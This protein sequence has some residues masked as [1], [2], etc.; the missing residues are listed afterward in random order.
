MDKD[1]NQ[2]NNYNLYGT[3]EENNNFE[4]QKIHKNKRNVKKIFA[5]IAIALIIALTGGAIGGTITYKV[6]VKNLGE[7]NITLAP[8]NFKESDEE[9]MS[10]QEVYEK[11]SPAVVTISTNGVEYSNGYFPQNVEGIGS[12]FIINEEGY[13]LTNYHVVELAISNNSKAVTV[14]L[15][16]GE[17]V[18]ATVVNYDQDRDIAMVKLKDGTKVPAVAQLGDSDALYVGQEVVAIG[19]PL[20]KDFAQ[21]LTKGIVSGVN[22][23][24]T[25]SG[26]STGNYI[27]TDTAINSGNSGGP[28]INSRGEVIGIN[29]AKLSGASETTIEGMGFA[30]PI[31]DAKER[32]DS[33]SKPILT[34]GV[35]IREISE[36][37]AATRGLPKGGLWV[38]GVVEDSPADK[39]GILPSDLILKFDGQ[40]IKTFDELNK[41][42]NEKNSGDKVEVV[43]YRN[44]KNIT[45][46]LELTES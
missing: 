19:T 42:K 32:I 26:G 10:A 34:L 39:A 29:T 36:E 14:I 40:E 23:N 4:P 20:G 5:S 11:V 3:E 31:N 28:L 41:A 1:E 44:G 9:A 43:V 27:Q 2:V 16:T 35:T 13:I 6:L 45:L 17:E 7:K 38:V 15:S 33:L 24:L 12:G 8:V 18:S 21:T 37:T 25:T 30:I 22:R 46:N